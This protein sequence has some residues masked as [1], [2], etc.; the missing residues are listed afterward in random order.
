MRAFLGGAFVAIALTGACTAA[1]STIDITPDE[2]AN[3]ARGFGSS[4]LDK[5]K[6]GAPVIFGRMDGQNYGIFL[7]NCDD[8]PS[9]ALIQ[10]TAQFPGDRI[11]I[12]KL[13]EWN[14]DKRFGKVAIAEDGNVWVNEAIITAE[15]LPRKTVE[16]YFGFW[17]LV[18]KQLPAFIAAK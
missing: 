3:I 8:K 10:F 12:A 9:C 2:V 4:V 14:R 15:G 17:Q 18:L 6:N 11:D 13:N 5:L 7:I 16:R 1:K